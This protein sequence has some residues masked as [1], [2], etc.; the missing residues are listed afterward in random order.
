MVDIIKPS[1]EASEERDQT[2]TFQDYRTFFKIVLC[3]YA[4]P[5]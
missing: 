3:N 5:L 2:V 1:T 4:N